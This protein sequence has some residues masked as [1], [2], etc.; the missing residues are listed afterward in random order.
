MFRHAAIL[1]AQLCAALAVFFT[2][3]G[4]AYISDGYG[5][6]PVGAGFIAALFI[7]LPHL[8]PEEHIS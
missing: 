1:A 3:E 2:L 4:M 7:A 5:V 6:H 8:I